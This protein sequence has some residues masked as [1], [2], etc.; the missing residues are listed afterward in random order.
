[1]SES[2]THVSALPLE[3]EGEPVGSDDDVCM[4]TRARACVCVCVTVCEL[5]K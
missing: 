4:C 1:M 5:M 3:K 2:G